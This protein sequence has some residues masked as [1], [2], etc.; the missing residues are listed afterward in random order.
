MYN[1]KTLLK[2]L[3]VGNIREIISQAVETKVSELSEPKVVKGYKGLCELFQCGRTTAFNMV[4]SGELDEAI[5]QY[6][7]TFVV[8][9]KMALDA[10]RLKTRRRAG[11]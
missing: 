7:K 3:T 4:K 5:S 9:S 6:G 10:Y 8:D 1:D 2:D 11:K